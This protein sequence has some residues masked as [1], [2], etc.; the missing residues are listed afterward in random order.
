M[1]YEPHDTTM[2]LV[3]TS[4]IRGHVGREIRAELALGLGQV[5]AS[6]DTNRIIV[7]R[8]HRETGSMLVDALT[9]GLREFGADVVT[10]GTVATPTLAR[11][12]RWL[13]GDL[14]VMVTASHNPPEYN[15]FKFWD[16][17]GRA[18]SADRVT[19]LVEAIAEDRSPLA[20]DGM[21]THEHVN[22][23]SARHAEA[24]EK[25]V[26]DLSDLE[27]I[28]DVGNGA[29][30]VAI[31]ALERLGARVH[32]MNASPDGRFP[33]RPSEPT[34]ENCQEL[35]A[36]VK[37]SS[38]DLG[39]ALDGDADRMQ[40]V[41]E[42]GVFVGGDVLLALFGASVATSGS[43]IVA[44]INTSRSVDAHL[45][46][47]GVSIIRTQIGDIH[48]AT[49]IDSAD[50]V[51]GGEPS[52]A[53]IWPDEI[54]C[55]DGPLAS[56][57]LA[58]RVLRRGS[59]DTIIAEIDTYPLRRHNVRTTS[60]HDA[61]ESVRERIIDKYGDRMSPIDGVYVALDDG[62]LLIR[63]SGTEP[64]IRITAEAETEK[65]VNCLIREATDLVTATLA[66]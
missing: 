21:G 56:C 10:I 58:E 33:N 20:W 45:E 1:V 40:A 14:G 7:G 6:R 53:W 42:S 25:V 12:V 44:P 15:G 48:V 5:I 36:T 64:M 8:D 4:G 17:S 2:S 34:A 63:P 61:M 66:E 50:A 35:Q 38:A 29:G 28:V 62:W 27:I 60:K 3:S 13:D 11:A 9:A 18:L 26:D 65:R 54:L 31:D 16:R 59:L 30:G 23:M 57:R 49:E 22:G 52:G 46:P 32:P 47:Q 19:E 24:I 37:D 41:T 43:R 55:P 39:V 51:F